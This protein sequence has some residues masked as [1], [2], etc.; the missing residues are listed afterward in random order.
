MMIKDMMFYEL[1]ALVIFAPG[2]TFVEQSEAYNEFYC[3]PLLGL[4]DN[5][6]TI[7]VLVTVMGLLNYIEQ[8]LEFLTYRRFLDK[9][10][11]F[12]IYQVLVLA[13]LDRK[14]FIITMFYVF[15]VSYTVC[16]SSG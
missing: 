1:P 4:T 5:L 7:I 15:L 6:M 9:N 10:I 14:K 13:N 11:F 8:E 3:L 16:S 12:M 2:K